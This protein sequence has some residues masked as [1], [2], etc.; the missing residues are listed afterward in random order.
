MLK[1]REDVHKTYVHKTSLYT[2]INCSVFC[3]GGNFYTANVWEQ[4]WLRIFGACFYTDNVAVEND[5]VQIGGETW[6]SHII[7]KWKGFKKKLK[8]FFSSEIHKVITFM[9]GKGQHT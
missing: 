1:K 9:F 3:N 8:H 7:V 6:S 4:E 5:K 2:D